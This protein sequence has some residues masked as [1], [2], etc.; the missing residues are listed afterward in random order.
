MTVYSYLVI[1]FILLDNYCS[2]YGYG[3]SY[4]HR[5]HFD[6]AIASFTKEPYIGAVWF[7]QHGDY[8]Y[9][10]GSVAGLPPGK[11]LGTHV[12]R[13]G[14]L[15]NMCL[16]AGP[17]FN[18]FNQ[19]HGPRHGYPRH[20][21]DLGNIRVGR[22]GVAKF[23]FYVTIKGLGPFDGFIGRALVIHA[24]RD[25][26]GRNRDEGS[27]TTGNSGPRLACATIGFRAP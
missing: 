9:V 22:G 3:Y 21:G 20:A 7:T 4:Y 1:L 23:D 12:H 25:D 19:R 5:R 26:L 10:N 6:P 11:L 18:P 27:R 8:M 24:N 13:Y 17:H 16:E 14:G 2:A 15:G